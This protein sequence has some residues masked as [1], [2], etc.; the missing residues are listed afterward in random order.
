MSEIKYPIFVFLSD[1][2][3]SGWWVIKDE[4]TVLVTA[5]KKNGVFSLIKSAYTSRDEI[6]RDLTHR[7]IPYR[8]VPEAEFVLMI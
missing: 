3:S 1:N 2:V 6:S 4:Q 8:E 7:N 5:N